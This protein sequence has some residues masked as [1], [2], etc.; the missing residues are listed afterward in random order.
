MENEL[1]LTEQELV[2]RKKMED[3]RTKGIDPFGQRFERTTNS[4]NIRKLYSDKTKE[5]LDSLAIIVSIAGRIMTKRRQGKVG[6]MHIQ[7][8]EGQIQIYLRFD[9]LGEEEYELFKV[10][11]IGD[12]VGIHG[13]VMRT[14]TGELSIKATSYIHLSKALR[15]LPEK[16]HGLQDKE[17]A[18]RR[19][20]VDLIMNDE[21]RKN[22][23]M[24]S[25]IIRCIQNFMDQRGFIEVETP[26]LNPILGGANARPF[27][28][29]HNTLDMDFYLRIATELPLK[30]LIVGGL[31]AVYEIGR[32]FRNEG[33]DATHNP[34]FTTIEAYLA[35]ADLSDMMELS[36]SLLNKLVIEIC[37]STNITYKGHQISFKAP[38][39]R[40]HMVDAINEITQVNFFNIKN[41]DEA[42]QIAKTHHIEVPKH[43]M[44]YGHI[45]NLFFEKY[46]E[47]TLIQPTFIYGHPVE[48]SPLAKKN[49][50]DSRFTDRFEL[51]I[52]GKEYANA[53]TELN[54]PIDQRARFMAQV[55]EKELGNDEATEMDIDYIE[56]LEYG[57]PPT[58]GIGIGIDRLIMLL[59]GCENIRDVILFPHMRNR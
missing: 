15:P 8:R 29:H 40:I 56:A 18:R 39:K 13:E 26:V 28:T 2:R 37:G 12:I 3:L 42:L 44:Y 57:M 53:F 46:V 36:E 7:D 11:D 14:T 6:F 54:D 22:A 41:L 47:D 38:F 23:I 17:E 48:I 19:R 9:V 51:F 24:R 32:L 21:S 16:Y 34:E 58:G 45:I 33:M 20:Y 27:I 30:R 50:I 10:A 59:T 55:K 49:N 35:Y 31:E 4:Q 1:H 25:K 5:E 43:Q 52:C